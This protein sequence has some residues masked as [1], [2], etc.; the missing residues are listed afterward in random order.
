MKL[1]IS[2]K[3]GTLILGLMI[4]GQENGY[5]QKVDYSI[6]SV[7]EE[8]GVEF[9]KITKHSDYVC[10]P[11]VRRIR[12]KI[13]W[14]SNCILA[15][16]RKGE[17]IAYLSYRN[18]TTNVFIKRLDGQGGD[19]KRT[20]RSNVID[21]SFSPDGEYLCFSEAR[22]QL[23][24]MFRTDAENGLVCR[25]I[26]AG[27]RDFSPV[28]SQDMSQIFFTRQETRGSSVWGFDVANNVLSSYTQGMNPCP[29]KNEPGLL[30]SRT[31][32]SGRSEIWKVNYA[33]GVEECIISDKERSFTSPAIS[34][35]G[36]Y[37][38]FVGESC[39][40]G[41]KIK[42]SNT[43]IFVCKIDGTE[44]TQLTYHAAD[45]LSPI[46]SADGRYIYF[47]SQRG[48]AQGVANIWRMTF[49]H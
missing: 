32:S 14:W 47:V 13:D 44:F 27:D 22:G 16:A 6:V 38:L 25:Q 1:K 45:D 5:A 39:I 11:E 30:I 49:K 43:D 3:F 33:T 28:Y 17:A 4:F 7:P 19:V 18:N 41:E 48:D 8:S 46:W 9:V 37:I 21:F 23:N 10:M 24:Q 35:D 2:A 20:N 36:E 12:G 34:P 15:M 40:R 42:Y 26:T 29:L 31:T